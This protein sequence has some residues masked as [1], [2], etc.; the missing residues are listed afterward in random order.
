MFNIALDIKHVVILC[1]C[2]NVVLLPVQCFN[3][4]L[5]I[6]HVVILCLCGNVVLLPVQCSILHLILNTLLYSVCVG[7]L[8]FYQYSAQYCT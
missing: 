4:A 6:K 1:L 3:I 2:G 8:Y 7:M 5:D